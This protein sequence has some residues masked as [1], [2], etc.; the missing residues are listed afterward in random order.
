VPLA[1]P[2]ERI[3]LDLP[4]RVGATISVCTVQEAQTWED[5]HKGT[6]EMHTT[7]DAAWD[8]PALAQRAEETTGLLC[9]G[10]ATAGGIQGLMALGESSATG[11]WSRLDAA[12]G[13]IV[14]VEYLAVH[15]A[16]RPTPVGTRA[17]RGVGIT[18]LGAAAQLAR[19]LGFQ[20][21]VGLHSTPDAEE[22][23]RRVGFTDVRREHC[24]DGEWLYFERAG[25][26]R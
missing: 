6:L 7:A 16:N 12:K 15:P 23:Y 22:F 18:L 13:A 24:D 5:Q 17:V 3:E 4:D 9:L 21:R 11:E 2:F 8:W 14:Y 26:E 20:G 10:L 1:T 25:D 19:A